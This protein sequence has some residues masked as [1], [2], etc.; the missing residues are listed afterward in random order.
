MSR[1]IA[2]LAAAAAATAAAQ[3][4]N[5]SAG[6]EA[7]ACEALLDMNDLTITQARLKPA[8]EE[9]PAHC[10]V[11]GTLAGTVRFHMQLPLPRAWNGRLVNIGDGGKDGDLDYADERLAQG[12]AVA[13]SNTGHDAAAQPAASFARDDRRAVIDFSYRAVHL[14][15][16]ASKA[17]V[18]QYYGEPQRYAYFDGCSTG[19]RQGLKE[20]QR[21]PNDFDGIVAGAPVHDYQ[22]TNITNL[23]MVKRMFEDDFAGNLAYDSD[24]DGVPD[25]LTKWEILRDAVMAVCDG[26]DGIEDALISDPESCGFEPRQHL[27][28]RTCPAGTDAADCFTEAQIRAIED[29]YRGPYDSRGEQVGGGM[30]HGSEFAWNRT[31]IPHAGNDLLPSR[32]RYVTDHMNYLFYEE[33]PGAPMP[34]PTDLSVLPDKSAT[35]PEFA[36]WEFEVD[37]FTAGKADAMMALTDATD[38]D[39]SRF[40]IREDA[41]LLLYHGWADPERP[42]QPVIDY[43]EAVVEQTF[44][45]DAERAREHVRLF[46]VPGMAH[47]GG[48]PGLHEWDRL[49]P[50]VEWVENGTAPQHIVARHRAGDGRV[51]NERRLCPYPQRAEYVG[52]EGGADDPANWVQTNFQCR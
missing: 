21:F 41:K 40:L 1:Y 50:L 52:P 43:Y 26:D 22:V 28:A 47:C 10:Y 6:A 46:M 14:T 23:W 51:D 48:G 13:N 20:A 30:N 5:A 45:D 25:D 11:R 34:D 24:G 4:P 39:L 49:A 38:P 36:W 2:A 29:L 8:G 3:Q 32:L 27:A 9:T 42:G 33:S 16:N 19:G 44:G 18:R 15:A 17:V 37:D 7:A 35:P 31:I 12:Y